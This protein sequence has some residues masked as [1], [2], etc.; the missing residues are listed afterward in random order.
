MK[1]ASTSECRGQ[2]DVCVVGRRG[3]A[4]ASRIAKTLDRKGF[5]VFLVEDG[6]M[7]GWLDMKILAVIS[8]CRDFVVVLG[9]GAAGALMTR[10]DPLRIEIVRAMQRERNVIPVLTE[11]ADLASVRDTKGLPDEICDFLEIP[12]SDEAGIEGRLKSIP[13]WSG[14]RTAA[15]ALVASA[16]LVCGALLWMRALSGFPGTAS[17]REAVSSMFDAVERSVRAYAAAANGRDASADSLTDDETR[18]LVRKLKDTPVDIVALVG[19]ATAHDSRRKGI[20]IGEKSVLEGNIGIV[21]SSVSGGGAA[22][23]REEVAKILEG[24]K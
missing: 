21:L 16:A 14:G 7:S 4:V 5:S 24:V 8:R 12:V 3:D 13:H 10:N 23:C 6:G 19:I 18:A 2:C 9:E 22:K 17:E 1:S 15:C 20:A 11:G